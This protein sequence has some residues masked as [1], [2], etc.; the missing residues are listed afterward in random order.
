MKRI[1][2]FLNGQAPQ[3]IP[4]LAQ[5]YQIY[6]TDGAYSY[7][8]EKNIKPNVVCGDF[9]SLNP[10]EIEEGIEIIELK[11]Q[12]F[13]DFEKALE[14]L[15]SRGFEEIYIYGSSGIEHDHFL[16]NLASGLKF[17]SDL[18]LIFFDDY[19][20]YFFAE[21]ETV[22]SGYKDRIIS[23][24]PFPTAENITTKGLKYSLKN[25]DLDIHTRIGIRNLA[26]EDEVKITFE[27]GDLLIFVR[28]N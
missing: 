13:T 25:E 3:Q 8:K 17:K 22:L 5:F 4:N 7:L 14:L 6:C 20:Y 2:L 19:S 26:K 24:Y 1:A 23:L 15:K 28:K 12:E 18:S 11:N 16:G 9:D 21:K 10:Q 27:E